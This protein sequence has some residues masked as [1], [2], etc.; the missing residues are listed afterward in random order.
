MVDRTVYAADAV[1][2]LPLRR[3]KIPEDLCKLVADSGLRS[4]ENVRDAGGYHSHGQADVQDSDAGSHPA[5][6][7]STCSRT[8]SDLTAQ[9]LKLDNTFGH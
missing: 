4:V 6:S 7:R 1:P 2:E 9:N 5:R 8:G 3:Q